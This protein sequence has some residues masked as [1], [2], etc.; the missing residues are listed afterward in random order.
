[1]QE[2]AMFR[3][4][5]PDEIAYRTVGEDVRAERAEQDWIATRADELEEMFERRPMHACVPA[6][7]DNETGSIPVAADLASWICET[8]GDRNRVFAEMMFDRS[9]RTEWARRWALARAVVENKRLPAGTHSD[10]EAA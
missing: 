6:I 7:W 1:M 8:S 5:Y 4:N 2:T 10:W 3:A 9:L